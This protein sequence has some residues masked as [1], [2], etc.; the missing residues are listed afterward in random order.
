SYS[1]NPAVVAE[2]AIAFMDEHSSRNI[3]TSTKHFP[4]HGSALADSHFGFTNITNTWEERE[5]DAYELIL[6]EMQPDMIMTG[7]LYHR[8][9]DEDHPVSI[10][11]KAVNGMLRNEL[12]YDG[13]VISDELFMQAISDNYTLDEALILTVNSGTDILLFNTN[14]CGSRCGSEENISLA[15]YAIQRIARA[16]DEGDISQSRIDESYERIMSLKQKRMIPTS[17][18]RPDTDMPLAIELEQNYPNPFNPTTTIRWQQSEADRVYLAVYDLMGRRVE[19]LVDESR[20]AGMHQVRFQ[21]DARLASGVY[22]YRLQAN[23]TS[24][25]RKMSLVK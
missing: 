9:F 6:D 1:D 8:D 11:H 19:V 7:H 13:V 18:E 4:G 17:I 2:H 3:I 5:L 20:A 15:R 23:G 22:L 10:S 16:V 14:L 21:A 24:I 12:G 25:T